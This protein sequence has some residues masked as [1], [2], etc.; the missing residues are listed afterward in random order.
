MVRWQQNTQILLLCIICLHDTK[1]HLIAYSASLLT[2][3][4]S[5]VW[6]HEQESLRSSNAAEGTYLTH[7]GATSA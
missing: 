6:V 2:T 7:P 3:S 4:Q 5:R 1:P